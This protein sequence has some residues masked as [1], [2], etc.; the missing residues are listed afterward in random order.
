MKLSKKFEGIVYPYIGS[1]MLTNEVDESV[2]KANSEIC[3]EIAKDFTIGFAEW[4]NK[5]VYYDGYKHIIEKTTKEY[6]IQQLLE[7]YIKE[8]RL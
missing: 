2:I 6:T 5:K 7:I 8:V 3:A 1:S 4:Y